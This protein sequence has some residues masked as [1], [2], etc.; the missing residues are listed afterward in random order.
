MTSRWLIACLST[1]LVL[2][3]C[4]DASVDPEAGSDANAASTNLEDTGS[5][6]PNSGAWG[7]TTSTDTGQG[8]GDDRRTPAD[9]STPVEEVYVPQPGEVGAQCNENSDCFSALCMEH[10]EGGFFCTEPCEDEC[11]NGFLC[12]STAPWRGDVMFICVPE[13]SVICKACVNDTDCGGPKHR[14]MSIGTAEENLFCGR[15]CDVDADCPDGYGCQDGTTWDGQAARQCQPE[16]G[17][18]ICNQDLNQTSRP[19]SSTNEWGTCYG[20]ELC[21]GG[22]GW[23]QCSAKLPAIES[24]DGLDNDCDGDT[25]EGHSPS[26][27]VKEND[28]GTCHGVRSCNGEVGLICDAL[29]PSNETCDGI[30]NNCDGHIDEVF[31]DTDNDGQADCMDTDD[32]NDGVEDEGDNCPLVANANQDDLDGDGTGDVC[33][34]D[35]DGDG[36]LDPL[37]SCPRDYNPAPIDTDSDGLDDDCDD[38]DDGDGSPDTLDCAPTNALVSPIS[39]EL[40]DGID[41]NCNAATDEAFADTDSD[42]QADCIDEDDDSDGDPDVSDCQ[43]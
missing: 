1:F 18:C 36:I 20:D 26:P 11:P 12:K 33:D 38:D 27:C 37:D 23:S 25:D 6:D 14:C 29:E 16:T 17:S 28:W 30:D 10:P 34:D 13:I 35:D 15:Y 31:D 42:G 43:P 24:C 3:S 4:G 22:A 19:C 41:N 40:C 8:P 32:D 2:A 9:T 7:G 21:D 39:V 5:T